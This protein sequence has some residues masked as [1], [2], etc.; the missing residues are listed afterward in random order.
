MRDR[1]RRRHFLKESDFT[2][3]EI[4]YLLDLTA[5]LNIRADR[6]AIAYRRW[7]KRLGMSFGTP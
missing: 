2:R 1:F 6:A 7:L 5:E 4:V 3:E